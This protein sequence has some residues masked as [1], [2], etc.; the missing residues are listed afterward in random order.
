M[1]RSFMLLLLFLSTLTL[2]ADEGMW[3]LHLLK[4]QKYPEM[5]RLG[6]EL[7]DYDI[8]NPDGASIK[9]AVCPVRQRMYGRGDLLPGLVL[10]NHHCGYG[11]IQ[12]H[13][14]LEHNYLEDGFWARSQA[15][16]LPNRD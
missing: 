13:N 6:L 12:S 9:D 7:K 1:R 5:K 16:E 11:T 10:T 4:Q 2:F 3:M 15:E 8:Y 14:A